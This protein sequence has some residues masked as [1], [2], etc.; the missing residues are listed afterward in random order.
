M[1]GN[2]KI[3]VVMP[4][5]NAE[6]TL[7]RTVAEVSREVVDDIILVDDRS[8]DETAA[9]ARRLGLHTI[10][11][12]R[13]R[14]YGGNQKTCYAAALVKG[15]DVVVMVHP[16][17][18]YTPRLI[19]ALA[20]CIVSGLYDVALGSRILGGRALAG[21]MPLY[22]YVSNRL[23][24]AA[25]NVLIDAKLSEYHTGY[26]AFSRPVLETL[27]LEENDDDFVFDNQMLVQA[28][29]FGYRI[30]EITCPTKYFDEASSISF[31]R[32][33][34][35]GLGVLKTAAELRLK[36]AGVLD[37]AYLRADGRKLPGSS[38]GG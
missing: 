29:A 22:K 5:Y 19:P 16:D 1:L 10:V 32:S 33:V 24:T 7:E 2:K 26:R 35:Y 36:R 38:S 34:K 17:Y 3:V 28:V 30:A 4:A 20:S 21:G 11:H 23:L 31:S 14:G 25:E 18:Q 6:A 15:A 9:V 13:N 37:P 8:T 27:P 12:D